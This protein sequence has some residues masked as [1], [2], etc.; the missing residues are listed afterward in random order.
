[1]AEYLT[2]FSFLDKG[3]PWPPPCEKERLEAYAANRLLYQGKHHEVFK[4][5][6][7]LLR[8]D[9]STELLLILN[10]HKRLSKLWADFMLGDPPVI[11]TEGDKAQQAWLKDFL[12]RTRLTSTAYEVA[13]DVSRYGDGLFKLAYLDDAVQVWAQPPQYWFLVVSPTNI[14]DVRAHVI[15]WTG[16][17]E[18]RG[19]LGPQHLLW[20]EIHQ[21]GRYERRVYRLQVRGEGVDTQARI[22]DLLP[23]HPDT[24][25]PQDTAV[26]RPLVVQATGTRASDELY[27]SDD[28]ADLETL[29][30][31][32]EVRLGQVSKVLDK[33]ADPSAY[34]PES[35]LE[36]DP[37]TGITHFRAGG[38]FFVVGE[39]ESAPGYL[40]WDGGLEAAFKELEE[41]KE[42]LYFISETSPAAFGLMKQGLAESGSALKR[43]LL[44]PLKKVARLRM[45]FD[46]ALR[47]TVL[48]ANALE[49]AHGD[50]PE[51]GGVS[52]IWRDG[53]PVDDTEQAQ[54]ELAR[55]NASTIS[56]FQAIKERTGWDDERVEAE[57]ERIAEE[58]AM[59]AGV[60]PGVLPP[61]VVGGSGGNT[62]NG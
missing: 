16:R 7:R 2:D 18:A 6:A 14:R 48:L 13:L 59:S 55:R 57:I 11:Q 29:V 1:M 22:L 51:L 46:P 28:Y 45:H 30:Q 9:L 40:T 52:I 53:L 19:F 41:L 15:A 25:L 60:T 58:D 27:G 5:W 39:G 56:R 32:M 34:G 4:D 49:A 42:Q 38:R 61:G 20:V 31:E 24:I 8:E 43:L 17:A 35:S 37:V 62:G 26:K 21:P 10:W 3:Q 44:A 54:T 50:A 47:E 33:H 36:R 23:D 12:E